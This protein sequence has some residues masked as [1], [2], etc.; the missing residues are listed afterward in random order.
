MFNPF[1]PVE[2]IQARCWSSMPAVYRHRR[3]SAW[4]DANR[5]GEEL[6]CFLEGPSF[7]TD[8]HL[9][10]VD[11]PFGRIFRISPD[12]EWNLVTE[13]DG[14]PNGLKIHRDGRIF[15]CDYRRGLLSLD[16]ASGRVTSVLETSYSEGFKGLNDLH[17]APNGDLYFTDQGQS[18]VADPSG[19]L[20]R[21]RASG[22]LDRL[23]DCI[24]SPNGVTLTADG[25]FC[26]LAA[27]RTQQIWRIPL[28][29]DGGVSKVGVA[30]QMSG[31]YAG[32]D[33]IE[34]DSDGGLLVCQLGIGVWRFDKRML[35]THLVLGSEDETYLTN[36]AFQPRDPRNLYITGS[37]TGTVFT[38]KMPV[39]GK[40]LF[41][42]S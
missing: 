20:Y 7:D 37:T 21:L 42:H 9:W 3:R 39:P 8:G 1:S 35:P 34:M 13:Y 16:P 31:G 36:L 27:T 28:M 12:G 25:R 4:S 38:A 6:E 26:Y 29:K 15:I 14:W 17:F 33:G 19:R 24:P 22:A 41:A 10:L 40:T 30:I 18:G 23:L 5:A 2:S 32:P 11:V